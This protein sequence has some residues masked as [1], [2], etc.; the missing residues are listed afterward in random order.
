MQRR[1]QRNIGATQNVRAEIMSTF[2][3]MKKSSTQMLPLASLELDVLGISFFISISIKICLYFCSIS[4]IGTE[5]A[6]K[7]PD[8]AGNTEEDA[9][10][11]HAK[12]DTELPIIIGL[13]CTETGSS[14]FGISGGK[15]SHRS[16]SKETVND[17]KQQLNNSTIQ[18]M[19][20]GDKDDKF[21]SFYIVL[22]NVF[23]FETY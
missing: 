19:K 11:E 15:R 21:L 6:G 20:V 8:A 1:K 5:F 7:E 9:Q 14:E 4:K 18:K 3:S 13:P 17:Q 23:N 22:I 12:E 2:S 10:N 16:N